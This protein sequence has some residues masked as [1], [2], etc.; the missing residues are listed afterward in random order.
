MG[1]IE[2][3]NSLQAILLLLK[4]TMGVTFISYSLVC[5]SDWK[6]HSSLIMSP[7]LAR[8]LISPSS[9]ECEI[10]PPG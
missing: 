5:Y 10:S 1:N 8:N 4:T 9:L 6:S 3:V 7:H 2:H